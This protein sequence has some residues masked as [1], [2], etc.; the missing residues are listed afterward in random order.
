M[1]NLSFP[2]RRPR[3]A[4]R[5]GCQV[6]AETTSMQQSV[7]V[8]RWVYDLLAMR[9]CRNPDMSVRLLTLGGDVPFLRLIRDCLASP[10]RYRL[11]SK[12]LSCRMIELKISRSAGAPDQAA[13][14]SWPL[15]L[16]G[17]ARSAFRVHA[18]SCMP[19]SSLY[20][21]PGDFFWVYALRVLLDHPL[22]PDWKIA[23]QQ[24]EEEAC[25]GSEA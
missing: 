19:V 7:S 24:G 17:M 3:L 6:Q 25:F 2:I 21:L 9:T 4:D 22:S 14:D 1:A 18:G 20:C 12:L 5:S 16:S 11:A 10:M 15:S 23:L 13:L 8:F